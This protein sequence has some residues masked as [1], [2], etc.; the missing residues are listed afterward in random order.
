MSLGS[1]SGKMQISC[2]TSFLVFFLI[3][4][5]VLFA[6]KSWKDKIDSEVYN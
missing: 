3:I 6:I 1:I 5:Q 4:K 2:S